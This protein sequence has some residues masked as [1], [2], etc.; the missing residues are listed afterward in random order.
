MNV[1]PISEVDYSSVVGAF[2]LQIPEVPGS[3][4]VA[5][6]NFCLEPYSFYKIYLIWYIYQIIMVIECK[7]YI[8][9]DIA[10]W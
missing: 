1:G 8:R 10:Q 6:F 3:N 5:A 4:P 7:S 9:S 2:G